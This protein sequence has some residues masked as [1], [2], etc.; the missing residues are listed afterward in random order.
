MFNAEINA[1]DFQIRQKDFHVYYFF[2]WQNK[3]YNRSSDLKRYWRNEKF[4][5]Y[6]WE[7]R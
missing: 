6:L 2:L 5:I 4:R 3:N 1:D 7:E